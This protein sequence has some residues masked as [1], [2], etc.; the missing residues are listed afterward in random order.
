MIKSKCNEFKP[1]WKNKNSEFNLLLII[2]FTLFTTP[3]IFCPVKIKYNNLNLIILM[4]D[5]Y[6]T[7]SSYYY[8]SAFPSGY[9]G[10][11]H[12]HEIHFYV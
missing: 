3:I 4:G 9:D 5:A 11:V 2:R 6:I 1:D 7:D 10:C 12:V 8:R